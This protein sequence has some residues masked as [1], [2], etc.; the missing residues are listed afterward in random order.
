MIFGVNLTKLYSDNKRTALIRKNVFFSF[1]IKGWSGLVTLLLVPLTLNCLGEYTNGV[2]I[3]ISTTLLWIDNM[4]IGLGNGLRNKL[5][6]Y[7]A[8]DDY[9]NGR[10]VVSS[11]FMMLAFII[12]PV[13]LL[14]VGIISFADIY[15]FLNVDE[16]IIPSLASVLSVS[17]IFVCA[18]FIFKFIGNFY[19][20]LQ[21][22]AVNNFLVVSGHT[23]ALLLTFVLYKIGSHSL[24]LIAIV[25]T[26]S[27]LVI[28]L[29]AYPYTFYVR[30]PKLR[31]SLLSFDKSMVKGV[32]NVG[33]KFFL[34]Q[35]C[36]TILFLSSS[37][38]I[39][40]IFTPA[41][42]TPYQIAYRYFS[43][44]LVIFTAISNP[45]WSAT[46][47]AFARGDM[48]WIKKSKKRVEKILCLLFCLLTMMVALSGF[49]YSIWINDDVDVPFSL[50]VCMAI[51]IMVLISSM[52]YSNF[53]N[54]MGVLRLQMV[55][56]FIAAVLF[57]PAS[58]VATS[59]HYNI[60]SIL[61]VLIFV[62]APGLIVNRIQLGKLLSANHSP[63]WAK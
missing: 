53:L 14:L 58:F 50:T 16:A 22:P 2:W 35:I 63:F 40:K 19:M 11:T 54:G 36:G 38:L 48:E 25:N 49:V 41:Y 62:N 27:P 51:Y 7:L 23:L 3:T 55:C 33:M 21:L 31:P 59:I 4:D 61:I 52:A 42:V 39:S 8:H 60:I 28:Y 56:T 9:E 26:C 5:A 34:L 24:M 44:V 30:Y 45:Y 20:G 37:L 12:I 46:T 47:D 17:V 10:K 18:T 15:S 43:L 32:F 1:L 13:L 6:T 57:I 29:I